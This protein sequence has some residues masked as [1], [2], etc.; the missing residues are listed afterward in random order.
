MGSGSTHTANAM[1]VIGPTAAGRPNPAW[2][3]WPTA[4]YFP[5]TLEPNGRWSLSAG[6]R[7]ADFR[8][9][10]VTSTATATRSARSGSGVHNGY[11]MPTLVWQIPATLAKSGTYRVVVRGV[12]RAGTRKTFGRTYDVRMFTP[13]G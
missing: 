1:T 3:S 12:H 6:N 10:T 8:R 9:A 4:G 7:R 11:G 5:R 13:S 2:V